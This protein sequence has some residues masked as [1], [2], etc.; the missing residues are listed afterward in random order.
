MDPKWIDGNTLYTLIWIQGDCW[1]YLFFLFVNSKFIPNHSN[2]FVASKCPFIGKIKQ[3]LGHVIG[4]IEIADQSVGVACKMINLK[5][6]ELIHQI[7]K[8]CTKS[9]ALQMRRKNVPKKR[10]SVDFSSQA[11]VEPFFQTEPATMNENVENRIVAHIANTNAGMER[12]RSA[13]MP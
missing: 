6:V 8:K 7:W 5:N 1:V 11:I 4:E 10:T 2:S 3:K 12:Q 9:A 13:K